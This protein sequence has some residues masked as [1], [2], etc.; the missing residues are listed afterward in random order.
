MFIGIGAW[1]GI[2]QYRARKRGDTPPTWKYYVPFVKDENAGSTTNYPSPRHAGFIEWVR[3]KFTNKRT[4]RGAYEETGPREG[5][6]RGRGRDGEDDAWDTRVGTRD[7]EMYGAG[8]DRGAVGGYQE[9]ELGLAPAGEDTSYDNRGRLGRENPFGDQNEAQS[10]RSVSPRP[11]SSRGQPGHVK[12]QD[13]LASAG[14]AEGNTRKS[15][16]REGI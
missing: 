4:A 8:P 9:Q 3:G 7:D 14:S 11:E 10:L 5:L 16:F 6:H 15:A 13:S 12:G 2:T 1:V